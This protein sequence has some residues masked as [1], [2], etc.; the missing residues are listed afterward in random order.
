M[1]K[2]LGK[3][4]L[5]GA[6]GMLGTAVRR[7]FTRREIETLT[8]ARRQKSKANATFPKKSTPS[9][10]PGLRSVAVALSG[11]VAWNPAARPAV[12][13]PELIE[14]LT[15][16][17]HL[18]GA[19]LAERRWTPR[20]KQEIIS[21]RVDSTHAVAT[22]L[23][24]LRQRPST[25]LVAS[26]VG[27]YGNRGD[28][29]LDESTAPGAGFLAGLCR[30]WEEAAQPAIDA[31]IRVIHLRFGVVI[32]SRSNPGM[33]GRVYRVFRLGLGGRIGSGKQW[34]SWISLTDL[35][36]AI[37]FLLEKPTISGAVNLTAPNPVTNE[38]F[39]HALAHQLHRPAMFPV[40]AAA[41]RLAFGEMADE[42]LLSST[43]A[44]PS[45]LKT[46][47]FE[48]AHPTIDEALSAGFRRL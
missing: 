28:E 36:E 16:A 30:E 11:E 35:V 4:L 9:E 34:M 10:R 32:G 43:R 41:L 21:S 44:F 13:H 42:A 8:L 19:N 2:T 24:G 45:R 27:I 5:S 3:Y 14:G 31:G 7:E 26:A 33:L 46:A 17:I 39:T 1:Q 48:F 40:P 12:P 15:A 18:S 29:M 22:A 37:F 20:Y 38:Q 25:L 47:G 6:S 23:A